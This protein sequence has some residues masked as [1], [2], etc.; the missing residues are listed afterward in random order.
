M[1]LRAIV[2]SLRLSSFVHARVLASREHSPSQI[3]DHHPMNLTQHTFARKIK[4]F[5]WRCLQ[6]LSRLS[7]RARWQ[8]VPLMASQRRLLALCS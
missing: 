8:S 4:R 1:L 5:N 6:Q 2:F 3:A 7:I